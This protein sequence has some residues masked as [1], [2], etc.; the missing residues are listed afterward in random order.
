MTLFT[1][2]SAVPCTE[3]RGIEVLWWGVGELGEGRFGWFVTYL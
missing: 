1:S 2:L 3:G